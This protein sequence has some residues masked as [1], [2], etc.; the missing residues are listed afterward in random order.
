MT[1]SISRLVC[2]VLAA[3]VPSG[4]RAQAILDEF[5]YEHLRPTA[6]QLDAGILGSTALERT[7]VAGA[8][9]DYGRIAPRV[10]VLLG[11]SYFRSDFD[12]DAT[13]RFERRVRGIVIDPSGDDT[14]S[15]GRV[16]LADL[17]AEL[18]LQY[19]VAESRA[20]ALFAGL[21]MGVHFRNGSGAAIAGTFVEDA[22]DDVAAGLNATLAGELRLAD[23]W[24]ATGELRGVLSSGL[25]T[26]SIRLGVAYRF[27]AAAR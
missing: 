5:S 16:S 26:A 22:L 10:R 18:D 7:V 8:R 4:V 23:A 15:V 19:A 17:V 14:I 1:G 21:G 11:L 20:G 6:L 2:L 25:S 9:L 13:A 27:A 3:G 12:P 24:R